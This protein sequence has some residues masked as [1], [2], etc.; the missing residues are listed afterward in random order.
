MADEI[1]ENN[2]EAAGATQAAGDSATEAN[3]VVTPKTEAGAAPETEAEAEAEVAIA[4]AVAQTPAKLIQPDVGFVREIIKGGGTDMKKCMQC[5]SCSVACNVTPDDTPF[6]R[7]E[8]QWAQWGLKD[9]L[10]GNPDIWLCHQCNDCTAQ[11]PRDAKPGSVMQAIAKMTISRFSS[12]GFLAKGAGNPSAL[13]LMAA[14][15]VIILALVIGIFGHFSPARGFIH[16]GE[17]IP[18]NEIIYSNFISIHA[19]DATYTLAFFFAILVFVVGV[20]RYWKLLAETARSEGIELKGSGLSKMGPVLGEILTH[21]RFSK[22][23]ETEDR[24]TAH[25]FIFYA[26]I[27]L[28]VTTG[29]SVIGE[30][31]AGQH[32]PYGWMN[33]VP[34]K[35]IG[36]VSLA[37]GLI[38][39][40]WIIVNR[41]KHSEK[42]GIGAYFDWL[43]ISLI[44]VVI[45]TGGAS[46][47][48]RVADIGVV[49]YPVYFVHLASVL[50]LFVYAP[51]S[52]MAHMVYRTTALAFARVTGRDTGIEA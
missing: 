20:S 6:P 50:F 24:K 18:G 30:Y 3:A 44:A 31:L 49:A 22:C 28:A 32:S 26:F 45:V 16:D 29:I 35:W 8:M 42:I 46:W 33:P 14:I 41:F 48:F 23:D 7:K 1:I 38:G 15:P 36:S 4:T 39:I 9:K 10:M 25:L 12:P 11:C 17:V 2:E 34:V 19:I 5:A 52:K 37:A 51:F 43:L 47:G 21:K 27:G 13:L 40:G